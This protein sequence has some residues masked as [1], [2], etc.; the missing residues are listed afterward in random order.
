MD[1]V[2]SKVPKGYHPIRYQTKAY[3]ECTKSLSAFTQDEREFLERYRW[4]RHVPEFFNPD[5]LFSEINKA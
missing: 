3:D 1:T 5:N 4:L 2:P